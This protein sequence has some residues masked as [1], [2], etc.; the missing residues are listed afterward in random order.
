M[1]RITVRQC[2]YFRAVAQNGGITTAAR[3]IGISQ[4]A[5]AQSI[6]KL[7]EQ[8]G[9]VLFNRHHARGMELTKQGAEFLQYAEVLIASAKKASEA[10]KEIAANRAG[11][12]RLGCF[13]S[14]APFYL[15][16]IVRDYRKIAPG[17]TLDVSELLQ[18][19]LEAGILENNLDLA[20][21][22]DL[23]LDPARISWNRLS[24][25]PPYLIVPPEHRL[26]HKKKV[27]IKEIADEDYILFD[28]PGS[29]DYFFSIF[30]DH[31]IGPQIAF[32]SSSIESVRCSVANGLGVSILA[33]R[34]ASNA[35]Y[36]G[37]QVVPL[38]LKEDL[39][40]T[41][42]VLAYREGEGDDALLRP[43]MEFCEQVFRGDRIA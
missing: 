19:E 8:T 33:M 43:F 29:R 28:A 18:G 40:Q 4:P 24:A 32:R 6:A 1:M 10:A 14:I 12:I 7:E 42:I 39:P 23:G 9:L 31:D 35:T 37:N 41:P 34:P 36:D 13:Q 27:S 25:A 38:E 26:A 16:K 5:V 11:T 3:Q 21:M 30:S 17:I 15:A 20:I 22:Y 2:E